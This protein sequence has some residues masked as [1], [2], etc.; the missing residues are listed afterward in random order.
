MLDGPWGDVSCGPLVPSAILGRHAGLQKLVAAAPEL[1]RRPE[2]AAVRELKAIDVVSTRLWFDRRVNFRYP[3]NVLAGFESH[4][5][6]TFFDLNVLQATLP[7]HRQPR[8]SHGI[9]C[10]CWCIDSLVVQDEYRDEAGSVVGADFYGATELLGLSDEEIVRKAVRNIT[11]CEPALK[12]AN[13]P[14]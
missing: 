9:R 13:V 10:Q 6:G 4:A 3:A 14:P 1:A 7:P 2:F 12:G 5:G 11:R 8:L